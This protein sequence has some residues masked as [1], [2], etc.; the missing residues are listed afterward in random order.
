M[1]DATE[2]RRILELLRA[3]HPEPEWACFAELASNTGFAPRYID[4]YAMNMWASKK[5]LK[6]AYEIKASRADFVRE[7]KE[8]AKREK[9]RAVADECWFATPAGLVRWDEIP[10]GWG[11]IEATEGGLR[12]KKQAQQVMVVQLPLTFTC[13]IARRAADVAPTLPPAAWKL[14]G[15][16]IDEEA[17]LQL[18]K[19]MAG[20][21]IVAARHE[22]EK[23][24]KEKAQTTTDELITLRQV[25]IEYLGFEHTAPAALKA[26]FAQQK[27]DIVPRDLRVRMLGLRAALDKVL[28]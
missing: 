11:L 10:E 22:G 1:S 18:V 23:A 25:I 7:L 5:N 8:P 9:A 15:R 16:E 28:E 6:V 13:A 4:L 24:A 17:L 20:D 2:T 27:G 19:E 3:R 12:V 21:Q 26:W 14:A